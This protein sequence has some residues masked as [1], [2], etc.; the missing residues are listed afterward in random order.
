MIKVFLLFLLSFQLHAVDMK[1]VG[2]LDFSVVE[3]KVTQINSYVADSSGQKDKMIKFQVRF[4]N[5]M[6]RFAAED[7]GNKELQEMRSEL[8]DM[9]KDIRDVEATL[10]VNLESLKEIE[11]ALR[12]NLDS[13]A[14]LR[15]NVERSKVRE[16]KKK[17]R[18][19]EKYI[20]RISKSQKSAN[21]YLKTV[22]AFL[23]NTEE[24]KSY[25]TAQVQK[26]LTKKIKQWEFAEIFNDPRSIIAYIKKD[27]EQIVEANKAQQWG[28]SDYFSAGD[29]LKQFFQ[30]WPRDISNDDLD[31]RV[32]KLC[33]EHYFQS[34]QVYLCLRAMNAINERVHKFGLRGSTTSILTPSSEIADQTNRQAGVYPSDQCRVDIYVAANLGHPRPRCW[35]AD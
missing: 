11:S 4:S 21:A 9:D 13:F 27:Y 33:Q 24:W 23:K 32:Q 35:Y 14:E 18:R 28:Q 19:I 15:K 34:E 5:F 31:P 17:K 30:Q 16:V 1:E 6:T 7:I 10:T 8:L 22:Q 20:K 3:E 2:V 29:C 25:L 26:G 12:V